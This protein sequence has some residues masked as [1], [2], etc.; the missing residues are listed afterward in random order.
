MRK[1]LTTGNVQ[2]A[3]E[4]QERVVHEDGKPFVDRYSVMLV[5]VMT[6]PSDHFHYSTSATAVPPSTPTTATLV[7]NIPDPGASVNVLDQMLKRTRRPKG[8]VIIQRR[9]PSTSTP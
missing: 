2:R 8:I 7:M 3:Q 1:T 4:C 9:I 5:I 6:I